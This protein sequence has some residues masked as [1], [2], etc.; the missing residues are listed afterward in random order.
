MNAEW[1]SSKYRSVM[2]WQRIQGI[3]RALAK[4]KAWVRPLLYANR[5]FQ[6]PHSHPWLRASLQPSTFFGLVMIGLVWACIPLHLSEAE[7]SAL[8][9]ARQNSDN[10]ARFFEEHVV[11]VV[12][13]ADK[14]LLSLRENLAKQPERFDIETARGY[15]GDLI[16]LIAVIGPDGILQAATLPSASGV[17]LDLSNEEH[18]RVHL[19]T[20]KDVLFISK[21][22]IGRITGKS[23]I[24]LT[25]R[26]SNPDDSFGGVIV[27]SIDQSNLSRFYESIDVGKD[28]TITVLGLD[29]TVRASRGFKNSDGLFKAVVLFD[30]LQE[31]PTGFYEAEGSVD[32]I[33][34]LVSYRKIRA[35]PLVV[36][37]GLAKHEVF[38]DYWRERTAYHISATALTVAILTV[39]GFGA[40]RERRLIETT[41]EMERSQKALAQSQERYQL[42]ESAVNDGIFDRNLITG[43]IYLSPR[44]KGILGYANDELLSHTSAF[45][46][47]IHPNDKAA[48]IEAVRAHLE[49]NKPYALDY[50]MRCKNGDYRW[51]HSRGKAVRDAAGRPVRMVGTITDISARKR[52]EALI[53][54]SRNNL[55]R[56]EAMVLL[57]HYKYEIGSAEYIWSEGVYRILGKSPGFF[58]PTL[59]GVLELVHP[60]DQSAV[61]QYR[62]D[63]NAGLEVPRLALRMFKDDGQIIDVEVWSMP[64]RASDGSVTGMFGTIQDATARRQAE[65]TLARSNEELEA[66]V[67]DRTAELAQEMRRREQAQMSL[68]QMQKMEAVGQLTAGIAHDFNN[69]LAVI[70]GSLGFVEKAATRGL[71]AEPELIDAAIRATRRGSELVRRLLAFVRQSPLQAEP[72]AVDQVVLDTLR[73]LQRTLGEEIEIVTNLDAMTATVSIDRNQMA[74]ALLNLALNSRDAMPEGGRLTIATICRPVQSAADKNSTRWPTGEEVCIAVSDTGTG[75]REDER[76]RVFEPFFTTKPDGLGSGLGLSMVQGFVEQSGGRIEIDSVEGRGTTITIRLPRIAAASQAD[77]TDAVGASPAAKEKTVLL[78][79][80]DP[81]VRIVTAALMKQLGYKVHAV[82]SGM[83]AIDLIES[84]AN[85]DITLTDIVLPGGIDGVALVKEAMRAR[86]GMGVLCMS[87]YD[88]TQSHRKWLQVQNIDFLEKPFS[89]DRL[90]Q[91][92]DAAIAR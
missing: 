26:L 12:G 72:T 49:A 81:D 32:G 84:P 17:R 59:N 60:D 47:R 3:A 45:S 38:A 91:A 63:L 71:T 89:S 15:L 11:R 22:L 51:V 46:D 33:R 2:T 52:A 27:A 35:L 36:T 87:G 70:Q 62:C 1:A 67:A 75:I 9:A 69:L 4:P 16:Q 79:E 68:A 44:W 43:E 86:P 88:P 6:H 25:R 58:T 48:V 61:Q 50:R 85:I 73:L 57:G 66:R 92:L 74:N 7:E 64:T 28:G 18:Y 54:E 76:H 30:K 77:E 42:V 55:A 56:A 31:S 21:P 39:I 13:D 19:N 53:E 29:K 24:Q 40:R 23:F 37:V 65:A 78:V 83:E 34:R 5:T 8:G 90:A 10:L 20:D 14:I 82:A 80:D 41:S